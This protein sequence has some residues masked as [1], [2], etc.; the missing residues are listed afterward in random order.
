M[1][2]HEKRRRIPNENDT[3]NPILKAFLKRMNDYTSRNR[4][5]YGFGDYHSY[6]EMVQWMKDIEYHYPSMAKTYSIGRTHE[7]REI[8]GIKVS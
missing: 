6:D 1:L 8:V 3:T 2:K 5:K 7:G 4:A